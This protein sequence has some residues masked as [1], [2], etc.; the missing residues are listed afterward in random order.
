MTAP[1]PGFGLAWHSVRRKHAG[2]ASPAGIVALVLLAIALVVGG[3]SSKDMAATD[4]RPSTTGDSAS[5]EP[6]ATTTPSPTDTASASPE[7]A[8]RRAPSPTSTTSLGS[9]EATAEAAATTH[10]ERQAT[11]TAEPR[12]QTRS[13][14]K[15]TKS[16]ST[17]SRSAE[18]TPARDSGPARDQQGGSAK[19]T[20][21]PGGG[22]KGGSTGPTGPA[23]TWQDGDAARQVWLQSD[24]VADTRG[25]R[26]S[27][28]QGNIVPKQASRGETTSGPVFRS[29]SGTRM[30]LPGGVLLSLDPEWDEARV[31]A[32]L[33]ANGIARSRVSAQSF[34]ANGYFVTTA[35]G[36]PSLNLANAL[37]GQEG[38]LI[39]SPNW[40]TAAAPK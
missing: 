39:S 9:L 8:V 30:T 32:F 20:P 31:N 19:G 24:P 38:V 28:G 25:A 37:A 1:A 6:A 16:A 15:S 12:R 33:A 23:Y 27:E 26:S 13:R 21:A 22:T 36:F 11:G 35:P 29:S 17:L 18:Q 3:C 7:P 2:I 5:S 10:A 14:L 40:E 34:A 4:T